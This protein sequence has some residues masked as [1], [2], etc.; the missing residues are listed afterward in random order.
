MNLTI[1]TIAEKIWQ[2][3]VLNFNMV[4]NWE[5]SFEEVCS[6]VRALLIQN[7]YLGY[8]VSVGEGADHYR[9]NK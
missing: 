8:D 2:L 5:T 9:Q 1:M 7:Q 6:F 3:G 4:K